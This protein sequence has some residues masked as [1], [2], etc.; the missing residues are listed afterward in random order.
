MGSIVSLVY[1]GV[2]VGASRS[3]AKSEESV[4]D[5]LTFTG[6]IGATCDLGVQSITLAPGASSCCGSG[7]CCSSCCSW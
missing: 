2:Q 7:C 3:A 5:L 4:A 1:E 6:R